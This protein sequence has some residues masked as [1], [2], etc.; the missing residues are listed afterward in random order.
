MEDNESGEGLLTITDGILY[1]RDRA[2][3]DI[4]PIPW[5]ALAGGIVRFWATGKD[6]ATLVKRSGDG[7]LILIK[8][9]PGSCSQ[10]HHFL[11]HLGL[12]KGWIRDF[13]LD[14]LNYQFPSVLF[15]NPKIN[16]SE[17]ALVLRVDPCSMRQRLP[18]QQWASIKNEFIRDLAS[19][20]LEKQ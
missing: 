3:N 10:F 2:V 7:D 9:I 16:G 17:R 19:R 4:I 13:W 12:E 8:T 6:Q 20:A 11:T 1:V 15:F 14:E 5:D 18:I